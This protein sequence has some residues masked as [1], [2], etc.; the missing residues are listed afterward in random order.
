MRRWIVVLFMAVMVVMADVGLV[1]WLNVRPPPAPRPVPGDLECDNNWS[2][3]NDPA[4]Q[5]AP[6]DW[7]PVEAVA[8]G[9]LAI[10]LGVVSWALYE[11]QQQ[12]LGVRA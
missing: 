6:L 7:V 11:P 5:T 4:C 9:V 1:V 12:T 3:K 10:I 8:G 2:V